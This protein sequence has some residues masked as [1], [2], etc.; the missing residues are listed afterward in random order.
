MAVDSIDSIKRRMIRNA[1]R[2]WGYSDV[3]DINSFDPVLNLIFGALAEEIR[4]VS[5]EIYQ[6]DARIIEKLLDVLFSKNMFTHFPAHAIATVK[7]YQPRSYVNEFYRFYFTKNIVKD[8]GRGEQTER[9]N[10]WFTPTGNFAIFN[11]EMKYL[12]FGEEMY[13][14]SGRFK[15]VIARKESYG[16]NSRSKLVFG[17]RFDQPA[18]LLD[19]LSLYFSFKNISADDRFFDAIQS[20]NWKVNGREVNFE[21]GFLSTE[22]QL[23]KLAHDNQNLSADTARFINEFYKKNFATLANENYQKSDFSPEEYREKLLVGFS[24]DKNAALFEDNILWIEAELFQPLSTEEINELLVFVN[25]FPVFNR[26]LNESTHTVVK[27]TNV[28]PLLTDDYFFDILRVTDS[29]NSL[30]LPGTASGNGGKEQ[31]SYQLR[32]GG[33]ARFDSRDARQTIERLI[34][35][36]RDEAAAFSIKG[37]ELISMEL[38]QLD[39][40]LS[41]LQQRVNMSGITNDLSS[42]LVLESESVFDKVNVEFWSLSG[43]L[44]NH[45]RVGERLNVYRG[46]DLND[47]S[48]ALVTQT[49]GG[50]QKLSNEDKLSKLRRSLLSRGRVVTSED[51]KALC[52][53]LFGSLLEKAEVKKGVRLESVPGKGLSRTLDIH[54]NLKDD[55][56]ISDEE[57][58][59]KTEALKIRLK[60]ESVNLLPYRIFIE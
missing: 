56:E 47:K 5:R 31:K 20:A 12:L 8:E 21:E 2:I 37:G 6:S 36:V 24:K 60:N 55:M 3:Q 44:A 28:I 51:I 30:F 16:E 34:D 11:A 59:Y 33:I 4:N 57:L 48:L 26:E 18:E 9:K 7:S 45:I 40:I 23:E 53:E 14:I 35:L 25:C 27:G 1:S 19:G 17:V 49:I 29:S 32:Q 10:I 42:Y 58:Q 15:D 22:Q 39:Q 43:E 13:E 41:R 46:S 52:F 38:K 50:R 54:L